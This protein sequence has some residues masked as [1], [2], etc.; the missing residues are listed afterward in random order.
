MCGF[1][2]VYVLARY[3]MLRPSCVE[4]GLVE[5]ASVIE[6]EVFFNKDAGLLFRIAEENAFCLDPEDLTNIS[7]TIRT[8]TSKT[9]C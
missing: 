4:D 7:E 3:G 8:N 6:L 1:V 2:C 5:A 9:N